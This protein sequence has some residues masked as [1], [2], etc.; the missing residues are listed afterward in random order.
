MAS[1]KNLTLTPE[2]VRALELLEAGSN[3]FLT[4][5]AGTGKSTLIQRFMETTERRVIVAAP[6]GVAA[7]N[8]EGY[9]LHRLFSFP[10]TVTIEEIRNG[11]VK[12]GRFAKTL[13]AVDTLI[14]D[15]SSMVRA[16]LFDCVVASLEK[17]GP[18]PG[19]PYGGVQLV[20]VGDLYQLPPVVTE[21]E[22][23]YFETAYE[24]PYF[25]SGKSFRREDFPVV[26]LST[27]F[28]QIGDTDMVDILNSIRDGRMSR[29]VN[30]R[31]N[32]RVRSDFEPPVDEFWLTLA[33]TNNIVKSRN[34]KALERI[35][36]VTYTSISERHGDLG[37][38]DV[39]TDD[40]LS[41]K[42]GAQIMLLNNDSAGRWVNGSLGVIEDV[43]LSEQT[44]AAAHA[45]RRSKVAGAQGA[46]DLE[47]IVRLRDG[48]RVEVEAH[49]WDITRPYAE[50]GTLRHE[51]VGAFTQLPFKL[52][53]AI[54]I[55][56]SQG[57]TLDKVIVDLA[58]GTQAT[59]QLYVAL[60]RCTS[61][62][63]LVLQRG[64]DPR[65][66]KVDHR[67][68][69]Y[70]AES[71]GKRGRKAS[72]VCA[73]ECLLVGQADGFVRPIDVAV[74]FPDGTVV[75]SLINPNRDIGTSARDYGL[76]AS[77]LQI[78]P[79][80]TE[81]WP[82]IEDAIS[83]Y[84]TASSD[85]K[86]LKILDDELKRTGIV[87]GLQKIVGVQDDSG[88]AKRRC[89]ASSAAEMA[90]LSQAR[91]SAGA[92]EDDASEYEPLDTNTV[93]YSMTRNF[94]IVPYGDPREVADLIARKFEG[95]RISERSLDTI[96]RFERD[97]G[98]HVERQEACD[99]PV[100]ADLACPGLRVCFTGSAEYSG[101]SYSRE[102]MEAVA[103]E[104]GF[105]PVANVTKTKCDVLVA[106]DVATQ[107]TKARSAAKWG[108][109][110]FSAAEFLAWSGKTDSRE[111]SRP[112][113]LLKVLSSL[114]S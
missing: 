10:P 81:T 94:E 93:G 78:A 57:Q 88:S 99:H 49:T 22:V 42:V 111:L 102:D 60:S 6:T 68:S 20:L 55:H 36:G 17:Y 109:P 110:V 3:L 98:V 80:L 87:T 32:S 63:G 48:S 106:A 38:F 114:M 43:R 83:G 33:A 7:L 79:T 1:S 21:G 14:I 44:Q 51:V 39:P 19:A 66:V 58:G 45:G 62:D 15:E 59:G 24:T 31:L 71:S 74:A 41:F 54:T 103:I 34:R 96:E 9:T 11:S 108:K 113:K 104:C 82:F 101:R 95:K 18:K 69:A 112:K 89:V 77:D 46:S 47:V 2:F 75:E 86:M 97:Y 29:A 12:P 100:F 107:S 16:D 35:D 53:W 28:R 91:V 56:K 70:L 5:K 92:C 90:K 64:V 105:V 73:L 84:G 72:K 40:E 52:A 61:L 27:V 65:D 37:R 85:P 50:G 30:A 4:G 25:F 8:V 23:E 26:Q 76:T 67:V 13:Q